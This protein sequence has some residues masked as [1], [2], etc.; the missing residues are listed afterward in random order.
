MIPL[1]Y[2]TFL[3]SKKTKKAFKWIWIAVATLI[4]ISMV[5]AYS[6]GIGI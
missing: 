1:S 6:G 4:I 2:M 5:F 3:Y